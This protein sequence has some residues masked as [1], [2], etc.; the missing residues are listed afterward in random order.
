VRWTSGAGFAYAIVDAGGP[1][2]LR[3]APGALAL[4][5][6]QLLDGTPV[7]AR[8]AGDHVM[9]HLPEVATGGPVVVR[10]AHSG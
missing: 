8:A 5:T 1:V 4:D 2:R 3:A 6:A 9:A 7:R 10:F